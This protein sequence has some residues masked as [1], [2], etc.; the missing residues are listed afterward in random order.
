M[1][2]GT[3]PS[4]KAKRPRFTLSNPPDTF[5][6]G[7][8]EVAE[9]EDSSRNVAY[10]HIAEGRYP[11]LRHGRRI[12]V[13]TAPLLQILRGERPVVAIVLVGEIILLLLTEPRARRGLLRT[14]RRAPG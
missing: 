9:L 3:T 4:T 10:R 1:P 6:V 14:R 13:L 2:S 5:T 7:V 11:C 8:N 12:R